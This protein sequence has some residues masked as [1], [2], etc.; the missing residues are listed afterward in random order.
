MMGRLT[1]GQGQLFYAFHLDEV[2]PADHVVRRIDAVLD[3]GWIHKELAPFYSTTGRPSIDPELMIRML[4]VGY[5][6][7]IRSE[8]RICAEV[9]VNLGYRWFCR[10]SIEDKI[11]DH[12][13]F[14]R[15]RHERFRESE[16]FRRVF[17]RVV[18]TCIAVGLVGGEAFSIDASLI[19]ADVDQTRRVP[20]DEAVDWPKPEEAS[21]AIA[22]YL[23]ALDEARVAED[24]DDN[25][26][27]PPKQISLTD[28]QAA[29]VAR[30]KMSPFFAYDAN[31]LIDNK[32]G[33]IVDAEGTRAN[34]SEET[35]VKTMIARVA[36]R[37]DLSPKRLAADTAYGTGRLLR[38]LTDRDIAPHIPVWTSRGRR[39]AASRATTS[40]MTKSATS[41][42]ALAASY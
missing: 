15:A 14:S 30:K 28:P 5:V 24:N 29:W 13:V 1:A 7:A 3:L 34:R 26:R 19:K 17:E 4:L 20:G 41:T 2:V 18:A 11:P 16:V 8:R 22:E 37:Y 12:S 31:Y 40:P 32:L 21:R 25:D 42:S 33:I 38:W 39:T 35:A 6:F 36:G 9:G 23:A 27:K 10:L